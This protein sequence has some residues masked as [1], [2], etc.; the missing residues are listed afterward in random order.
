MKQ[1]FF[2]LAFAS[3]MFCSCGD[4]N[5]DVDT[6]KYSSGVFV[7]N[8]GAFSGGTGTITYKAD[9][10]NP[11]QDAYAAA[12]DGLVL[13]NILQSMHSVDDQYF[14][15]VN[16]ANKIEVANKSD[17]KNTST[18]DMIDLP[19]YMVNTTDDKAYVSYWGP[20]GV[21]GGI[22]VVDVAN[23]SISSTI[24]TYSGPENMIISNGFL[25][26][27]ISGGFGRATS[28]LKID[29]NTDAVVK[30]IELHD[31]PN[32]IALDDDGAI[33]VV[34]GGYT[35]FVDPIN[36]T[37]GRLMQIID[38][39]VAAEYIITRGANSLAI[40]P[41]ANSLYYLDFNGV[42]KVDISDPAINFDLI[43]PTEGYFYGLDVRP[44]TGSLYIAN[45][46]D[47]VSSGEVIV[48]NDTGTELSRFEA[49]IIPNGCYF[50]D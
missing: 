48:I 20:D 19:R 49:G 46:R 50:I 10:E 27:T 45:A 1:F 33:W 21:T 4:N 18:I 9:D 30:T 6:V 14:F 12:N 47:F 41:D 11:I 17:F 23:M 29:T 25:Y 28:L 43:L 24:E 44:S 3:F 5:L 2:L 32:S 15:I 31:N 13:G 39:S 34:C 40:S 16:N 8:E 37:S 36:N 22:A 38:D 26:A 42:Q 35:D 7:T